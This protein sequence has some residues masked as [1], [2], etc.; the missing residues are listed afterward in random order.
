MRQVGFLYEVKAGVNPFSRMGYSRFYRAIEMSQYLA[1]HDVR[2]L[3]YSPIHVNQDNSTV[4]GYY[5][6][7]QNFQE[8][9][10]PVPKVNANWHFDTWNSYDAAGNKKKNYKLWTVEN[11]IQVYLPWDLKDIVDDKKLSYEVMSQYDKNLMPYSEVYDYTL[12]QVERFL[13]SGQSVFLKPFYS[14]QGRDIMVVRKI[15]KG[16]KLSYY[17]E[18]ETHII[19]R[20]TLPELFRDIEHYINREHMLIQQ[21][22]ETVKYHG[23][24]FDIR[25]I[26]LHDGQDWQ[27]MH[28]VRTGPHGSD[29]SYNPSEYD[30][31][32][33]ETVLS[34]LFD[35]RQCQEIINNVEKSCH[36]VSCHLASYAP[37]AAMELAYDVL[38]TKEGRHYLAETNSQPGLWYDKPFEDVF[39]LSAEEQPKYDR[40]IAPHGKYLAMFMHSKLNAL[41]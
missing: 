29:L 20:H 3:I 1:K 4:L 25:V 21:G 6:K 22:V 14:A 35:A 13:E 19:T 38:L 27:C 30:S 8:I 37:G 31:L 40:Q 5:L 36:D 23:S 18:Y 17:S 15:K 41:G 34:E 26:M 7:D 11:N 28:H 10:A 39:N 16:V 9:V 12:E 2:L 32:E 24:S 33:T